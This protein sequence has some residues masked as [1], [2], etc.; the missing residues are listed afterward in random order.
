MRILFLCT[1]NSARSQM[2]E[3][4]T[5]QMAKERQLEL[6]VWSAGSKPAG[7]VHPLAIQAMKELGIDISHYRSKG[8]DQVSQDVDLVIT[9]CDSAAQECPYIPGAKTVHIGFPDP[10]EENTLEAFR[11]VRDQIKQ[12]L[13]NL[14]DSLLR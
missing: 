5:K 2:A 12:T 7:Y 3:A 9:L 13:E 4:L 8:L 11:K 6:E 14:M 1:G 10:A